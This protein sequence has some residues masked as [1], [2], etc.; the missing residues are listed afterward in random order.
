V[1]K[2]VLCVDDSATMQM[3][4]DITFRGTDFQ[5]VGARSVDEAL[6][7]AKAGKPA[8][9]LADSAMPG[10]TGY[11]LCQE[12]KASMP[13]VPVVILVGN[14]APYDAAKGTAVGA[15]ANLP[16]PWDTQTML[17][18]VTEIVA[19]GATA[20]PGAAA[21]APA[22]AKPAAAATPAPAAAAAA[23][24]PP[25]SATIMG[26]PTIKMPAGVAPTV[27][28]APAP[29][30]AKTQAM[31]VPPVA[32][33]LAAS[34]GLRPPAAPAAQPA[35]A[36]PAAASAPVISGVGGMNRAPMV[37]GNPTKRSKLV[38]AMLAKMGQR[39][40]EAT[41]LA[42]G[43]PELAA[44]LKLSAEVVERVVWEV[45]PDLAEQIIRENLEQLAAA[46]RS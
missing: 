26:M 43:S 28:P 5:Y 36:A 30:P 46:R 17:E 39:L 34:A 3:V 32:A 6:Q 41:G 2:I 35:A 27:T 18:K 25:R 44:L 1:S 21:A 7:K 33:N 20:K 40:A 19:K 11:D 31:A 16:K 42:E 14:G 24:Q 4:A 45:V 37:A 22:A 12:L 38:D 15:D 23:N 9:V 13:D 10:K 8:V 29:V